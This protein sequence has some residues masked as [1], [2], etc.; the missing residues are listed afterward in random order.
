MKG[1]ISVRS[2]L[3]IARGIQAEGGGAL[4]GNDEEGR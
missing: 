3:P 4:G 2:E 1:V